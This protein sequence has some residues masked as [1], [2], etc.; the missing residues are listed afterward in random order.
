MR[1]R[2]GCHMAPAQVDKSCNCA[3]LG[4][5]I[6]ASAKGI[7]LDMNAGLLGHPLPS[8][9]F[10]MDQRAECRW[11]ASYG[12]AADLGEAFLGLRLMNN[13]I[14]LRVETLDHRRGGA[15]GSQNPVP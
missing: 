3:A 2:L 13:A 6:T 10:L 1:P 8:R 15:R 4:Q 14:E 5:L 7:S 11:R 9:D 12:L